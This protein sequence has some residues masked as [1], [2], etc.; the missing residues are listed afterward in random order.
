MVEKD[1]KAWNQ[2]IWRFEH[3]THVYMFILFYEIAKLYLEEKEEEEKNKKNNVNKVQ[4]FVLPSQYL[5]T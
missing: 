3:F 5:H 4:G 2:S 1:K